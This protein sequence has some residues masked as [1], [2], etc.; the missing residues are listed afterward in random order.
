MVE[1][2]EAILVI[3]C[4]LFEWKRICAGFLLFVYTYI[5]VAYYQEGDGS[6]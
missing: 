6:H 4:G 2:L 3:V 5:A 1:E